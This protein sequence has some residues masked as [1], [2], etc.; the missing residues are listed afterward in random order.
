VLDN[1]DLLSKANDA[2]LSFGNKQRSINETIDAI[3]HIEVDRL[4]SFREDNPDMFLPAN[5]DVEVGSVM[6]PDQ[7]SSS[8]SEDESGKYVEEDMENLSPWVEV[9][10]KR[11]S[12]KRKLVFR[13]NGSRPYMESKRS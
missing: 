7:K 5:L 3:K 6:S 2:G 9:F 4:V 8:D 1:D 11:S 10:T 12:S 13:S